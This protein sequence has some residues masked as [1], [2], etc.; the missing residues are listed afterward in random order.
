M[1]RAGD[2]TVEVALFD[3]ALAELDTNEFWRKGYA[4]IPDVYTDEEVEQM[5]TQVREHCGSGGGELATSP[6]LHVLADGRMASV[7]KKLLD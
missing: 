6:M 5:R 1:G 3:Q 7:A 2:D 4:I